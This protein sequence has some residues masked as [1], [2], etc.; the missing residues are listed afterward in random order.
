VTRELG[1]EIPWHT[2]RANVL[3]EGL[4][5]PALKG[6]RVRVGGAEVM[7]IDET[8]PCG[9]MDRQHEGLRKALIPACRGG[10]HGRV[11][12]A[13]TFHVGDMVVVCDG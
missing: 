1:A 8:R 9:L 7:L 13:G 12:R 3:V 2:R 5:L 6:R 10:L 11:V 4:D